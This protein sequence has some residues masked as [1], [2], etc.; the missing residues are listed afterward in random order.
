MKVYEIQFVEWHTGSGYDSSG[1]CIFQLLKDKEPFSRVFIR[2]ARTLASCWKLE[3][4]KTI[5]D[6][7]LHIGLPK[8]EEYLKT[9]NLPVHRTSL[10]PLGYGESI[11]EIV[12]HTENQP[13]ERLLLEKQCKFRIKSPTGEICKIAY[14][15]DKATPGITTRETCNKCPLPDDRIRCEYLWHPQ[16]IIQHASGQY[17]RR[18]G[19]AICAYS[20]TSI[21]YAEQ[22]IPGSKN[23]WKRIF[24]IPEPEIK[25]PSDLSARVV[26]EIDFLNI[27]FQEK[28]KLQPLIPKYA[29]S[30]HDLTGD[31][32]TKEEFTHKIAVIGDL[33]NQ[34]K[35]GTLL[36]QGEKED[37]KNKNRKG[38]ISELESFLKREYPNLPLGLIDKLRKIVDIRNNFPI[39]S[40]ERTL[41]AFEDFGIK[42][43]LENWNDSWQKILCGFWQSLH[44]LRNAIQYSEQI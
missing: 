22:C 8:V 30:I 41:S 1:G 16:T 11:P 14:K 9:G 24:E 17:I 12:L 20:G 15:P 13:T 4:E 38:S 2:M 40:R 10:S 32:S 18:L 27:L 43:P 5:R 37:L 21:S 35:I 26:D 3:E 33:I 36:T 6:Y 29:R 25:I 23:C 44:E 31:C 19:E 39:H 28:Y 7:L 34:I 42:Y